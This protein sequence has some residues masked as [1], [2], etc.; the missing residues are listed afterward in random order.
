MDQVG[1][2]NV[3]VARRKANAAV[4]F[5]VPTHDVAAMAGR[6]PMLPAALDAMSDHF[7]VL[8]GGIPIVE[9]TTVVGGLGIAGGHYE[10]DR[11][12]AEQVIA[13][14]QEGWS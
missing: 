14:T 3:E 11:A 8:P 2:A 5:G 7:I 1:Y 6:D 12:I 4:N 13:R 9:I 10:Q